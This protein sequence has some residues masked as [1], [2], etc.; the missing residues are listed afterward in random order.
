MVKV[1]IIIPV[2]NGERYISEAIDSVLNQT[3][4]D[5]EIIVIDDGSKDNTS[6]ILRMYGEKIRWKSQENKGPASAKK[7]GTSMTEGEYIT[8]LDSD[9]MFL[10]DK[11]KQQVDYLDKHPEV[12]L[13]YSDYYQVDE[14]GKITKLISCNKKNVPLIQQNYVP[15]SGVMCRRECFDNVGVFDE[16]LGGDY[17]WDMWLRISEKYPIYCIPKPLFK[18]R[19]HGENISL[20]RPNRLDYERKVKILLLEKAYQRRGKPSW[21]KFKIIRAKFERKIGKIWPLSDERLSGFWWGLNRVID[22]MERVI[23]RVR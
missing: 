1:S 9:D 13:V 12:G 5:F 7:I 16:S 22:K 4:R 18:Y 8:Y 20:T 19:V 23:F 2:Y 17:D 21:L 3:Y 10:P 15:T 14:K 11:L 6:N